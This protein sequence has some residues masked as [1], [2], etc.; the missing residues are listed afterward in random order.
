MSELN[1][2][3]EN[4]R[5]Y[6]QKTLVTKVPFAVKV[7]FEDHCFSIHGRHKGRCQDTDTLL[8][9][10]N[11]SPAAAKKIVDQIIEVLCQASNAADEVSA[12]DY[13][14]YENIRNNLILRPLNYKEHKEELIDVPHILVGDIALVLYITIS[15]IGPDYFTAK[16]KRSQIKSWNLSEYEILLNA[17]INTSILYPPFVFTPKNVLLELMGFVPKELLR[18]PVSQS[19]SKLD[20]NNN[21][22]I[23]TNSLEINGSISVFYPGILDRISKHL[24]SDLYIAFTSIH[25]AQIHPL[26]ALA[27]ETILQSLQAV[28]AECNSK[29]EF[30]SNHV[31]YYNRKEHTLSMLIN[32]QRIA[33]MK[34]PGEL[35]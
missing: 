4:V 14:N 13:Y 20:I 17:L 15:K 23:L 10:P 26:H 7:A 33:V 19:L 11:L 22:Y 6:L 28:N 29:N 16:F 12:L 34:I 9:L 30:L 3:I 8:N 25:E 5:D 24:D 18:I 21:G 32:G 1:V 31:F 2:Q 35:T 27:P